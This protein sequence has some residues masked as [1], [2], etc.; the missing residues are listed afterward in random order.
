ML[1][2]IDNYKFIK[3]SNPISNLLMVYSEAT[4]KVKAAFQVTGRQ[5]FLLGDIL[6]GVIK[7]GMIADLSSGGVDKRLTI[8]AIEFALHCD[9]D[10]VWEDAGLGFSDLTESEKKLL[11]SQPPFT[12]SL[13]NHKS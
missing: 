8:E 13:E 10:K 12:I 6:S 2:K 5:F 7:I 11:Q 3:Q 4:F 9:G 1:S